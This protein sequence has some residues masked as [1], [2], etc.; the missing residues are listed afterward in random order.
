MAVSNV[1]RKN[2][3]IPMMQMSKVDIRAAVYTNLYYT[4]WMLEAVT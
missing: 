1:D 3:R 2:R 4:I